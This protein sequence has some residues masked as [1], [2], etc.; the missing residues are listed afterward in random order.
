MTWHSGSMDEEVYDVS[1]ERI[2]QWGPVWVAHQPSSHA[3]LRVPVTGEA[4]SSATAVSTPHHT[5]E[6]VVHDGSDADESL[7]EP[8]DNGESLYETPD[9]SES[10]D[11]VSPG[12]ADGLWERTSLASP[13]AARSGDSDS[14]EFL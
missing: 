12:A 13:S 9:R 4:V 7:Y 10:E 2:Q 5:D 3:Q 14:G 8:P 1:D 11:Y 6:F